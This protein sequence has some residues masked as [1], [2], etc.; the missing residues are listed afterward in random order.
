MMKTQLRAMTLMICTG[1]VAISLLEYALTGFH[2]FT[3]L[4]DKEIEAVN[5]ETDLSNL[6]AHS[7]DTPASRPQSIESVNAIGLLPS[8]PGLASLSVAT[9]SGPALAIMGLAW[10]FGK[11]PGTACA[12]GACETARH[13]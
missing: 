5:S 8:G 11:A 9:I 4:R 13:T 2:P 1:A 3:R 7:G 6:F 10:W 12:T